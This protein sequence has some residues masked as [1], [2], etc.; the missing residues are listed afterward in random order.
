MYDMY[1]PIDFVHSGI[2][3]LCVVVE[4]CLLTQGEKL[5]KE[6]TKTGMYFLFSAIYTYCIFH[7]I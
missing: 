5:I 6:K 1:S 4:I 7:S 2:T 3:E